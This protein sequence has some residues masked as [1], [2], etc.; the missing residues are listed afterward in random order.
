[1][2][3]EQEGRR[4]TITEKREM[5]G[6]WEETGTTE[7]SELGWM[8]HNRMAMASHGRTMCFWAVKNLR[9]LTDG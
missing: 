3:E 4:G 5:I 6:D 2:K 1:M 8:V 7:E 9:S